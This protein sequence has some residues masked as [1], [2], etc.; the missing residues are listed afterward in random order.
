MK[1]KR[2]RL[3]AM[4]LTVIVL[5]LCAVSRLRAD[6]GSCNGIN[7]TLPFTD[8]AGNPFFCQIAEAYF[9][10]LSNG[11]T[12]TT[13]SPSAPVPREQM[14]AFITRAQDSA[15]RRGSR[16]AALEHW[17]T[18]QSISSDAMTT[19]GQFPSGL[20]SD[21]ADIWVPNNGSD[22]VSRVRASDG[23]L[24]ETWTGAVS[25]TAVLVAQGRIYV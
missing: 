5:A 11:T 12:A 25:A 16:R 6:A 14:A 15:L 2:P 4:L 3:A 9:S 22:T 24:L 13:Y 1:I 19:V 18:P 7:L 20:Q 17:A 21:G 10:G 23:K 8:V